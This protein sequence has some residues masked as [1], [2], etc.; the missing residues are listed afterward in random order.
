VQ[1]GGTFLRPSSDGRQRRLGRLLRLC[2]QKNASR[3]AWASIR[4]RS[5][6]VGSAAPGDVMGAIGPVAAIKGGARR[7]GRAMRLSIFIG[8]ASR[9]QR[10]L[11]RAQ[12]LACA[13]TEGLSAST[14]AQRSKFKLA[15]AESGHRATRWG[16]KPRAAGLRDHSWRGELNGGASRLG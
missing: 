2:G 15:G 13:P 4:R 11:R 12:S 9:Y 3:E 10:G 5:G 8:T 14:R 16:G 7:R 1:T 6:P